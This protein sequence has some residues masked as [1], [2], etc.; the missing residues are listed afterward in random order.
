MMPSLFVTHGA[1]SL[2][3][4]QSEY[5]RFLREALPARLER[6]RAVVLFTAHW[7]ADTQQVGSGLRPATM[8]DFYGWP[9]ELYQITYPASGD[10]DGAH[11]VRDL[12]RKSGIRAEMDDARA[13]DHGTWVV[14]SMLYPDA[15]LPV[16][17][18]SVNPHLSN[19]EQYQIGRALAI[20]KSEGYLIIGSGATV[21]N[22]RALDW[23]AASAESWTV[24]FDAWVG[25]RLLS[26]NLEELFAYEKLAPHARRAAPRN[27][28]FVPLLIAMGAGDD[29]RKAEC[30]HQTYQYGTLSLSCWRF[31]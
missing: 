9:E 31:A 29:R 22:L 2:V 27:E 6:P 5:A 21:H 13:L 12:L 3:L 20:L 10:P 25:E 24:E 16:V 23:D 7:E 8:H 4:E 15:S 28:H 1:P 18:M 14:M 30:L 11:A 26:W 19:A 17:Q